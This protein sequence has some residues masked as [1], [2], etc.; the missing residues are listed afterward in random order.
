MAIHEGVPDCRRA[1]I[2][3]SL[4]AG[5][6]GARAGFRGEAICRRRR[7]AHI[8][9]GKAVNKPVLPPV[10]PFDKKFL[11]FDSSGVCWTAGPGAKELQIDL[12]SRKQR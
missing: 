4:A 8:P 9:F 10:I 5:Y 2:R 3:L 1:T 11:E 7:R 6:E 12:G